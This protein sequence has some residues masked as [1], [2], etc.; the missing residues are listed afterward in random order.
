MLTKRA[1]GAVGTHHV[2]VLTDLVPG[3]VYHYS[4]GTARYPLTTNTFIL[5]ALGA[6]P[7]PDSPTAPSGVRP[8]A[9]TNSVP[10]APVEASRPPPARVTWGNLGSLQDHF[11]RHGA[12]FSARDPEHYAGLAWEFR[13]RAIRENWSAKRDEDGV[14]RIY[15]PRTGGFAAYNRNG[16]TKTYFKPRSRSYFE[17]Q[18]GDRFDLKTWKP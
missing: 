12:D 18:P 10:A 17:R 3:T 7:V 15:D 14:V 1:D 2:V 6:T 13:E 4:V 8:P 5:P 16:T 9:L 11:D